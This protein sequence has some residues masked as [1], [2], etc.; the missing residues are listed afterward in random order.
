MPMD[1]NANG[2]PGEATDVYDAMFHIGDAVGPR[3]VAH[4]PNDYMAEPVPTVDVT[5]NEVVNPATFTTDQ[6]VMIGPEGAVSVLGVSVVAG[7]DGRTYRI[8][9][10]QQKTGGQYTLTI[11]PNVR[12]VFGNAMD[13]DHDDSNGSVTDVYVGTF[14]LLAVVSLAYPDDAPMIGLAADAGPCAGNVTIKGRVV[15]QLV[16]YLRE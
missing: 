2:Q 13:Q 10:P 11:G 8:A 15:H 4:T 16:T 14:G 7:T 1:Q 12:D 9:I 6:V 5:F 3:V